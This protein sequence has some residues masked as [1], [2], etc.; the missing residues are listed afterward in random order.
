M[1]ITRHQIS[2]ALNGQE[3]EIDL[4]PLAEVASIEEMCGIED[5]GGGKTLSRGKLGPRGSRAFLNSSRSQFTFDAGDEEN[6]NTSR[7][8]VNAFQVATIPDGYNSGRSYYLQAESGELKQRLISE[9]QAL[10]ASARKRAEGKTR[11]RRAQDRV[12]KVY[13]DRAFQSCAA[14][15]IVAVS[16]P[17][18]LPAAIPSP[19]AAPEPGRGVCRAE[20][21]H[22]PARPG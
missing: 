12:R 3:D 11:F 15:L 4:I 10:A 21:S 18:R 8:F 20:P 9:L 14:V 19:R 17:C 2:F 22:R 13:T 16:R 7:L 5:G 6:E 1:I